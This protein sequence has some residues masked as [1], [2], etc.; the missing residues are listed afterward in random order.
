M[1][2]LSITATRLQDSI[3][4]SN[5]PISAVPLSCLELTC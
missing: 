1:R 3:A 5:G 4:L 2:L